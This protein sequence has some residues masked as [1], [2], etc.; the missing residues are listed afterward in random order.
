VAMAGATLA[1]GLWTLLIIL[2]VVLCMLLP[3]QAL[4]SETPRDAAEGVARQ[5]SAPGASTGNNRS[6]DQ[7]S[8][9]QEL[10]FVEDMI[11]GAFARVAAQCVMYPADAL[12]TLAQVRGGSAVP[13]SITPALLIKGSIT[14]SAMALPAGAIQFS[15]FPFMKR[16]CTSLLPPWFS[17]TFIEMVSAGVA[18]VLASVFQ[19]PQELLK[20]R[21]QT[22]LYP[23]FASGLVTLTKE[24]G[25]AGWFTG[26]LPT[27]AR[28]MPMVVIVFTSF[29][30]LKA[31]YKTR[32]GRE[33]SSGESMLLGAL[34]GGVA[35]GLTQPIDV[36]KTRLMTQAL[37]S[38]TPYTGPV[39]CML[40]IAAEEGLHTFYA[41][42][43][44]RLVYI[45]P[46]SAIQFAV[47]AKAKQ[48]LLRR[49]SPRPLAD[50]A[51]RD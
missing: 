30:R 32:T 35:V 48:L 33:V 18:S 43:V 50:H 26:F 16:L 41:G 47:N 40:R 12:K 2:A 1:E 39:D 7:A 20:Q 36:I 11:A 37:S 22:G 8:N 14:T 9:S 25:L 34:A 46:F 15:V 3:I 38:Q 17:I 10:S 4:P 45:A 6:K 21:I 24:E 49:H 44:P 19:S 23:S 28:N 31:L 13:L 27:L 42:L 29:A 51:R 5:D